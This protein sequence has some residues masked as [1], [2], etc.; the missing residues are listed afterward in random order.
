LYDTFGNIPFLKKNGHISIQNFFFVTNVKVYKPKC[1][2][3][4]GFPLFS[5]KPDVL[6]P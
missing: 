4:N 1:L 6:D 3:K 2:G 5:A